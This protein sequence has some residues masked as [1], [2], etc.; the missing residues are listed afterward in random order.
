MLDPGPLASLVRTTKTVG[1][2]AVA[3]TLGLA[4]RVA[5]SLATRSDLML[6]RGQGKWRAHRG[7]YTVRSEVAAE[8]QT[9][10]P[11]HGRAA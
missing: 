7:R 2:L 6:W 9:P 10:R 5:P 8:A 1:L 3:R 4:A 11:S